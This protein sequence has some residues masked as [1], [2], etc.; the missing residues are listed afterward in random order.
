MYKLTDNAE[1]P[2][3]L[4]TGSTSFQCH[5]FAKIVKVWEATLLDS[6]SSSV[7][8]SCY[9]F[10]HKGTSEGTLTFWLEWIK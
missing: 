6:Q 2:T 1:T 5:W 10:A 9:R 4:S 7:L 8:C 3:K